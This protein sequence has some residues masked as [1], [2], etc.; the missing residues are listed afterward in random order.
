M[1]CYD[2]HFYNKVSH[3]SISNALFTEAKNVIY[4]KIVTTTYLTLF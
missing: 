2:P 3:N 4:Y 1:N